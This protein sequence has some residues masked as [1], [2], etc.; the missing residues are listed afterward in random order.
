MQIYELGYLVLPSL[1]EEKVGEVSV[2]IKKIVAD[3]GGTEVAGEAP[4]KIELAYTMTKTVGAS[5][6]V[7]NDAYI[8]WFKFEMEPEQ[9][10][11]VKAAVESMDEILR[12]L[13][14]KAPRE[15]GFTFAQALSKEKAAE[16][17]D[18]ART[19]EEVAVE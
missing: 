2:A 18:P 6:Y 3:H 19:E 13:L 16:E 14:I 9:V 1:S 10:L 7:V 15:T 11:K 8:G 5:R 17:V 4:Q 12:H